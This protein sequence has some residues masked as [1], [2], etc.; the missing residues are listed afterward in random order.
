[1]QLILVD[2]HGFAKYI[3]LSKLFKINWLEEKKLKHD[4][5]SPSEVAEILN[6]TRQTVTRWCS[7]GRVS[8]I[9]LPS[10]QFRIPRDEVEKILTPVV[11][12]ASS[13]DE[14]FEDVPLFRENG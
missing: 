4:L 10:G 3:R 9:V 5:L 11:P 13:A 2:K 12:S 6:V 14:A 7:V 1:M 8:Y